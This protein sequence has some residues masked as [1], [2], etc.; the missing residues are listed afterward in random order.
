MCLEKFR[1]YRILLL[2]LE[3]GIVFILPAN[4]VSYYQACYKQDVPASIHVYPTGGHGWGMR[5]SF[6][7]HI[8]MLL[9]LKVWLQSF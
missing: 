7:Y 5:S 4:G 8:E 1:T 3:R 9:E 6:K 2:L